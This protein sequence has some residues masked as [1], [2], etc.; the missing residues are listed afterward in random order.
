MAN[1]LENLKTYVDY[2]IKDMRSSTEWAMN[3]MTDETRRYRLDWALEMID[4]ADNRAD[5]AI[6][7]ASIWD[8]ENRDN[9]NLKNEIDA[10][11]KKLNDAWFSEREYAMN[12]I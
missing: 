8:V 2:Q 3:E 12:N 10:L 1:T 9:A 6:N 7:F 5:G 4:K 11:R